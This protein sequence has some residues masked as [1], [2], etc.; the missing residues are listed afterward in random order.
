MILVGPI[1]DATRRHSELP[2]GQ[3]C[4]C[5]DVSTTTHD[6]DTLAEDEKSLHIDANRDLGDNRKRFLG[7]R[8]S[9]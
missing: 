3:G 9:G 1:V 6:K 4:E 8:N 2:E 7:S 5:G